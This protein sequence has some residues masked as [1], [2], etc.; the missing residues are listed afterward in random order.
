MDL[1]KS[2]NPFLEDIGNLVDKDLRKKFGM[3]ETCGRTSFMVMR[4]P[5]G[6]ILRCARCGRRFEEDILNWLKSK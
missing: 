6:N 2:N 4:E 5:E 3:C 1:E